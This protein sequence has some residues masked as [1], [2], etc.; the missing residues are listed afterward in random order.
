M[1]P[2]HGARLTAPYNTEA[3]VAHVRSFHEHL[4]PESYQDWKDFGRPNH[5]EDHGAATPIYN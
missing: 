3:A 2:S 1:V 4:S 5:Q